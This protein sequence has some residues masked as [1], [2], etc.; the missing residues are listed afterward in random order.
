MQCCTFTY[1]PFRIPLGSRKLTLIIHSGFS[2]ADST[3]GSIGIGILSLVILAITVIIVFFGKKR[4]RR[5]VT[6]GPPQ[7]SDIALSSYETSRGYG[8]IDGGSSENV[9]RAQSRG[10]V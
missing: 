7:S 9:R 1:P 10:F 8:N 4:N 2:L 6:I 5:T 3:H